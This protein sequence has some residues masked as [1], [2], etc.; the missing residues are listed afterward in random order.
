MELVAG[1][2]KASWSFRLR[3][4]SGLRQSGSHLPRG[5]F[6]EWRP[7]AKALGY[8]WAASGVGE[9]GFS[10]WAGLR[11]SGSFGCAQ[12]DRGLGGWRWA[13]AVALFE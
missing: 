13:G 1:L 12:D 8:S 5:L 11:D 3:M 2:R 10:V 9:K 6:M 7:K 4:H